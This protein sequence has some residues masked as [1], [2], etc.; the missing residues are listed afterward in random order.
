MATSLY[1][2]SLGL[3]GPD[4]ATALPSRSS[5]DELARIDRDIAE[6]EQRLLHQ[7]ALVALLEADGECTILADA[8]LGAKEK[9]LEAMRMRRGMLLALN[10]A[11]C[12]QPCNLS[13]SGIARSPVAD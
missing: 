2:A 5:Q 11:D 12:M 13:G 3:C 9:C 1:S 7:A 10:D 6:E 8:Q 4:R